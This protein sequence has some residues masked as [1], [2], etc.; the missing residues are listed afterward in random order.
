MR[1][2]GLKIK[3]SLNLRQFESFIVL[4]EKSLVIAKL[5]EMASKSWSPH[6]Q[7]SKKQVNAKKTAYSQ[8][9][10]ELIQKFRNWG[11]PT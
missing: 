10:R 3:G 2:L 6:F 1:Q 5:E 9:S 8:K 11:K 7:G 4:Y